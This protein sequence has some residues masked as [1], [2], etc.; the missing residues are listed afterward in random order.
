MPSSHQLVCIYLN[1][2]DQWEHRPLHLEILQFLHHAGCSG[3]TVL[4]GLAGFTAG[5]GVLS[6]PLGEAG[7]KLPV[8]VQ[9][10]DRA[11][12]VAEVMP[13]LR[14]MRGNRLITVQD[15]Q[16]VAAGDAR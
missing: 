13:T 14:R 3:G 12:K 11:E 1:E 7:S 16:V 10:V 9:F 8:V 6:T 15:V 2:A 4:R 5:A